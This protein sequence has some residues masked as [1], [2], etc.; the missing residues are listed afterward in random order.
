MDE[1]RCPV[2]S[3]IHTKRLF[4][5]HADAAGSMV[6][7]DNPGQSM[8]I[9]REIASLWQTANGEFYRCS[10]CRFGFARPFKA[11]N[12]KI[13]SALYYKDFSYP[14]SKWE[15][16]RALAILR[17]LGV[18]TGSILLELGAGNGTFL[19]KVSDI[20]HN[21][22]HIYSTEYSGAG[23][24]EIQRKG[25][26]C[27]NK[28]ISELPD[29]KLPPFDIICMFQVLEHMDNLDLVFQMLNRLGRPDAHLIVA[30]PNG[31]LRSFYDKWGVHLDIPPIHVGRFTPDTFFFLGQKYG[32]DLLEASFEPQTYWFKVKKFIFDRYARQ[33]VAKRAEASGKKTVKVLSRYVI[34]LLLCLRFL[35]VLIYLLFPDTGTSLLVHFQKQNEVP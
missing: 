16:E 11:G 27:F 25:F 14:A 17:E 29:E 21:R 5:L 4:I 10:N 8:L 20:I 7:P 35:P 33:S 2:C 13:Y 22:D 3:S 26:R 24:E 1:I 6:I 12:E 18:S 15:Y 34:V 9:S 31:I 23:M 30:V 32:W 19:E 28:S